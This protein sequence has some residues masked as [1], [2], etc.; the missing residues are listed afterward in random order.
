MQLIFSFCLLS[1]GHCQPDGNYKL[2]KRQ[3][4][5]TIIKTEYALVRNILNFHDSPSELESGSSLASVSAGLT[6]SSILCSLTA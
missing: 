6:P 1:L 4:P 2:Y 5:A 3:K